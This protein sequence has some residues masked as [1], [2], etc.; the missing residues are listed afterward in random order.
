[1]GRDESGM[2]RDE[3]GALRDESADRWDESAARSVG[4]MLLQVASLPA[5]F[6]ITVT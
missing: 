1:M 2:G 4:M 6:C 3:S 5:R